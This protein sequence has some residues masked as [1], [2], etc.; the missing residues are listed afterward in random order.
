MA[1]AY[2]R[3]GD[4]QGMPGTPSLGDAAGALA[5]YRTADGMLRRLLKDAP[6]DIA[7]QSQWLSLQYRIVTLLADS[8][9]TKESLELGEA[10]LAR[11]SGS[12]DDRIAVGQARLRARLG[13]IYTGAD[14]KRAME[15]LRIAVGQ[16]APVAERSGS[17]AE[18]LNLLA[19]L[20]GRSGNSNDSRWSTR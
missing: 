16:L 11:T 4:V 10:A 13:A 1:A 14:S 20:R 2:S 7:L 6:S 17:D 12:S 19:T 3:L 8:Q 15:H 9:R 5:S 18:L